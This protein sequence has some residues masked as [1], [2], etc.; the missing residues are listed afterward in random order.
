[1]PFL[2]Q[3]IKLLQDWADLLKHFTQRHLFRR[4]H[5]WLS[6]RR[7]RY[8]N[9][10]YLLVVAVDCSVALASGFLELFDT[11]NADVAA[12]VADKPFFLHISGDEGHAGPPYT[13]H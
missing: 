8:R 6:G 2:Q 9:A 3:R 12:P 13:H 5:K 11:R 7:S 4:W 10:K 1:M